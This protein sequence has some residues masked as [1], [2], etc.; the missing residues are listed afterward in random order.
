MIKGR[1]K[2]SLWVTVNFSS[3]VMSAF[4]VSVGMCESERKVIKT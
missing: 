1:R 3:K 2:V 4:G